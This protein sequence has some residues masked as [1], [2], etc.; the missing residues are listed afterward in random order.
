[1]CLIREFVES[2]LPAFREENPHLEVAAVLRRGQHP[3][4]NASY[5]EHCFCWA[6]ECILD[7]TA[8]TLR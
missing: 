4:L 2:I 8:R 5:G 7:H 6:D 1:M 3:N